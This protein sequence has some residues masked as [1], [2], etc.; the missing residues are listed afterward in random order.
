ME[1]I[2]FCFN[3]CFGFS[4]IQKYIYISITGVWDSIP[5]FSQKGIF[6]Y[7][8]MVCALISIGVLGF[9]VWAHHMFT[10]GMHGCEYSGI[11]YCG[12][13]DYSGT[14]G[15]KNIYLSRHYF[16]RN[17]DFRYSNLLLGD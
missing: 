6:G 10:V 2:Q 4:D 9:I 13:Y 7:L 5:V 1:E 8:G 11:F 15:N 3:I 17:K 12:N 14:D 16:R